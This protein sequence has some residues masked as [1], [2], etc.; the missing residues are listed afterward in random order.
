MRLFA[1]AQFYN[2]K[3]VGRLSDSN[4][5]LLPGLLTYLFSNSP[6]VDIPAL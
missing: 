5:C 3:C 1:D 4:V 2:R 6:Q